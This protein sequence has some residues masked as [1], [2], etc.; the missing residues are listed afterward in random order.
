MAEALPSLWEAFGSPPRTVAIPARRSPL[1]H[2]ASLAL[3]AVLRMH[4][5]IYSPHSWQKVWRLARRSAPPA[6][7]TWHDL[8]LS[9]TIEVFTRPCAAGAASRFIFWNA[10]WLRD[11]AA[12]VVVR[13]KGVLRRLAAL[14][15][16]V[17]IAE[18]HWDQT[19]AA[20]WRSLFPGATLHAAPA[21]VGPRGGPQG[22]GRPGRPRRICRG[23]GP[24]GP[25]RLRRLCAVCHPPS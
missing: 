2:A 1:W 8:C 24:S 17:G 19:T 12:A 16:L 14:G 25:Y 18:T 6:W 11:S 13:K 10:R 20:I 4:G 5:I 22:G 15:N 21:R 7:T 23:L 9:D 3:R